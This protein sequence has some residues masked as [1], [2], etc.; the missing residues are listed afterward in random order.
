[1][2]TFIRQGPPKKSSGIDR[3]TTFKLVV[4]ALI[5]AQKTATPP[6]LLLKRTGPNWLDQLHRHEVISALKEISA[7][8][9]ELFEFIPDIYLEDPSNEGT[10]LL[11]SLYNDEQWWKKW[12]EAPEDAPILLGLSD[13]FGNWCEA[14]IHKQNITLQNLSEASRQKVL[15]VRAEHTS[16]VRIDIEPETHNL[17]GSGKCDQKR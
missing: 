6:F 7:R 4:D 3:K 10:G 11:A 8:N 5:E 15:D 17:L 13:A 1:M 16:A 2:P 14:Q 12:Q 9:R